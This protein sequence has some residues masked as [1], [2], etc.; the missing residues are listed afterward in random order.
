[1]MSLFIH[2]L[3]A[4]TFCLVAFLFYRLHNTYKQSILEDK[5]HRQQFF[6]IS[7]IPITSANKTEPTSEPDPIFDIPVMEREVGAMVDMVQATLR[8]LDNPDPV[9]AGKDEER[10]EDEG[11]GEDKESAGDNAKV[12][13]A[14]ERLV[15]EPETL[16][17]ADISAETFA[18]VN[19]S[20][21]D[22]SAPET[23][24]AGDGKEAD[25]NVATFS[26]TDN[27]LSDYIGD[28]FAGSAKPVADDHQD[29]SV[30]GEVINSEQTED[31]RDSWP[32]TSQSDLSELYEASISAR[33]ETLLSSEARLSNKTA[34]SSEPTQPP[35]GPFPPETTHRP[36]P[37]SRFAVGS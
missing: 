25:S 5:H 32:L 13:V 31:L 1:M 14:P 27:A 6:Q 26:S 30:S 11:R 23:T 21:L 22:G 10:G 20:E 28:F 15:D 3:E 16:S 12:Q 19:G 33:Q 36:K 34:S 35:E 4:L 24:Y 29:S 9:L 18:P 8:N 2:L 37:G 17:A 7:D